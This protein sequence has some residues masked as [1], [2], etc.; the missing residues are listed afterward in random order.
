[1]RVPLKAPL[2]V[3]LSLICAS[4][5]EEYVEE[6]GLEVGFDAEL[7][8]TYAPG[9]T[10]CTDAVAAATPCS[11]DADCGG[12]HC[13]R[14]FNPGI[15]WQASSDFG[16]CLYLD[17][18]N[19]D[20]DAIQADLCTLPDPQRQGR[21]VPY[22]LPANAEI[23]IDDPDGDGYG[24]VIDRRVIIEGQGSLMRVDTDPDRL[25]VTEAALWFYVDLAGTTTG[26]TPFQ[27]AQ[28]SSLR[29]L[30]LFPTVPTSPVADATTGILV[31]APD[32]GL[33]N[34]RLQH[35]GR[36]IYAD[37]RHGA[38][39]ANW[40]YFTRMFLGNCDDA[41][42]EFDGSDSQESLVMGVR[43]QDG[44]GLVDRANAGTTWIAP[45]F[46]NVDS[47][48]H[49]L[50]AAASTIVGMAMEA[51]DPDPVTVVQ[52][53]FVGGPVM[54][55]LQGSETRVGPGRSRLT[56]SRGAGGTTVAVP[57]Q[58]KHTALEWEHDEDCEMS[59]GTCTSGAERWEIKF[60]TDV[61]RW[62][63][64]QGVTRPYSW[65]GKGASGP[66]GGVLPNNGDFELGSSGYEDGAALCSDGVDNDADGVVD[67]C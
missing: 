61:H 8:S 55:H 31:Q 53:T 38:A 54:N 23:L 19:S 42:I 40:Q 17:G 39:N 43:T 60:E 51:G 33:D 16:H 27:H 25:P 35:F 44:E 58:S 29:D 66:P 1:M 4:C 30:T 67:G 49:A 45:A 7:R 6:P 11:T 52:N 57:G 2:I 5:D 13:S 14:T 56:F 64:R 32:L 46:E 9:R 24:L 37:S 36:C 48:Y 12:L 15:E 47:S 63:I 59:G 41:S 3:L 18:A 62:E 10:W 34:L 50:D 65:Y 26:L 22:R 28:G 20:S 21:G